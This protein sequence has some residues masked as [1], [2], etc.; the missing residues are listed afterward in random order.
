MR[1]NWKPK[2]ETIG[3]PGKGFIKAE[4]FNDE[5]LE[6]LKQRAK[7]RGLDVHSFL[8][9]CGLV[10]SSPQMEIPLEEPKAALVTEVLDNSEEVKEVKQRKR[11]TKKEL[12]AAKQSE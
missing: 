6:N 7:N 11:R 3:V 4:S 2:N 1:T 12:E 10:P 8:L 5:D 9:G